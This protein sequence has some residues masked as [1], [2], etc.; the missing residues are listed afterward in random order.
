MI[1]DKRLRAL[2]Q[3]NPDGT[4]PELVTT[5]ATELLALRRDVRQLQAELNRRP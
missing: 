5:L 4:Y 3:H 1:T 2:A